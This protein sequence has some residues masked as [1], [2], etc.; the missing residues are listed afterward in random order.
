MPVRSRWR[1]LPTEAINR[2]TL[3]IDKLSVADIVEV[4][5]SD[6]RKVLEAV[7]REKARIAQ[8]SASLFER[9]QTMAA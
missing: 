4:M 7:R 5:V 3:G 6:N 8:V 9:W 1:R 2:L